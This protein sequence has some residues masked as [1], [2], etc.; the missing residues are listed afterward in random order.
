VTLI[1]YSAPASTGLPAAAPE[2]EGLASALIGALNRR[3]AGEPPHA[4]ALTAAVPGDEVA[5]PGAWIAFADGNEADAPV[6]HLAPILADGR[7]PMLTD[8]AGRPDAAL[9]ATALGAVEP[10]VAA[11]ELVLGRALR[12]TEAVAA[13]PGDPV[14][15]L[16]DAAAAGRRAHRLLLALPPGTAP[17]AA[18]ALPLDRS[19]LPDVGPA[20]TARIAGPAVAAA[21]AAAIARGDLLL[22]GTGRP[23]VRFAAPGR[24]GTL[25]GR[26]DVEGGLIMVD[27]ELDA[28][29]GPD[30]P[31]SA[32]AG[33]PLPDPAAHSVRFTVEI[34]GGDLSFERLATL[35][36]GSVVPVADA[37]G[38]RLPVRLL[39][40]GRAM[41]SGD[42]VA[43]GEGYG[44]LVTS[45]S[46]G[47][48]PDTDVTAAGASQDDAFDVTALDGV[49]DAPFPAPAPAP[50]GA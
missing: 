36:A 5:R 14:L 27:G 16:L 23:L 43:V 44:V 8:A 13:V 21:R 32:D 39:A 24:K 37:G 11:L 20:W 50:I 49:P 31:A 9:A 6:L 19:H 48:A 29:S 33:A 10:L 42:L 25:T 41:A 7:V 28:S 12:P 35:G 45:V 2:R 3:T 47:M 46:G 34:E 40:G 15:L 17:A 26:L 1:P 18:G 30:A 22:L 4:L 38:G